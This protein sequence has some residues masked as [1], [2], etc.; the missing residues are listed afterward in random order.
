MFRSS[1]QSPAPSGS[2]LTDAVFI[3]SGVRAGD[4]RCW[5]ENRGAE[6]T[7]KTEG[8]CGIPAATKTG[9]PGLAQFAETRGRP[10]GLWLFSP[11]LARR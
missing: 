5:Q 4:P 6:D 1:R 9:S 10:C 3:W 7:A 8:L 2:L 11:L